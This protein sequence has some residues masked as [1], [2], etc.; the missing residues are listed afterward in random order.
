MMGRGK[1]WGKSER[2]VGGREKGSVVDKMGGRERQRDTERDR[3]R[4]KDP[5]VPR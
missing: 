4:V 5:S 2:E 3:D 1:G